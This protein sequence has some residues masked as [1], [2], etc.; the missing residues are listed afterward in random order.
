MADAKKTPDLHEQQARLQ[1][2]RP[3][4]NAGKVGQRHLGLLALTIVGGLCFGVLAG[5]AFGAYASR[6]LPAVFAVLGGWILAL[7]LPAFLA[8]RAVLALRRRGKG[9]LLQRLT[10]AF[11]VFVTQLTVFL[12]GFF[13]LGQQQASVSGELALAG[14]SVFGSVPVLG[15]MLEKHARDERALFDDNK[16]GEKSPADA[17]HAG[18][19]AAGLQARGLQ[20]RT[21]GGRVVRSAAAGITTTTGD[22][23]VLA[24]QLGF[25]GA[26]QR[27]V[28]ELS[29]HAAL[30]NPTRIATSDDGFVAVVLGGSTLLVSRPGAGAADIDQGLSR[31]A[32]LHDL[33]IQR[34]VDVAVGPGGSLLCVVQGSLGGNVVQALVSR[35]GNAPPVLVARTGD[36]V[37]NNALPPADVT[38]DKDKGKD[39]G[40]GKDKARQEG[41]PSEIPD[42][43]PRV[44]EGRGPLRIKAFVL[45]DNDGRGALLLEEELLAGGVDVGTQLAGG[46]YLMNPRR[47]L[48]LRIDQPRAQ[49]EIAATGDVPSGLTGVSLQGF[50]N[51]WPM[52]D[53]RVYFDANF[54][55]EGQKGWFFSAGPGG[56]VF[57]VLPEQFNADLA[58]WSSKAPRLKH[59]VI[60]PDGT[61]AFLKADGSLL[62]GDVQKPAEA[63]AVLLR[64]DAYRSDGTRAGGIAAVL[65]PALARGGEWLLASVELL[66][67]AGQKRQAV[68]LSSR[69]DLAAG[70]TE[71]LLEEGGLVPPASAPELEPAKAE[72]GKKTT[73]KDDPTAA[74]DAGVAQAPERRIKS[75][76]FLEG[77]EELLWQ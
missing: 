72:P 33:E 48:S 31:G 55:E 27:R 44:A 24:W 57:A 4:A 59:L 39:K 32:R 26:A 23:V 74:V 2:P 13:Q 36:V 60:E 68:V 1:T 41:K 45:K 54:I 52:P 20:A 6:L 76:F 73:K 63:K 18:P 14:F 47:L 25:G 69:A 9:V 15:G 62:L 50:A 30:G 17:Q 53:G 12:G 35:V 67:D 16:P 64:G 70:K 22:I 51:A 21:A 40:L 7:V 66:D 71:V 43:T 77:H 19:Q 61:F 8:V 3:P 5:I 46:H 28:I 11:L 42:A 34:I 10:A 56:G 58:P 65:A 49:V 38:M 29:A 37:T 75:L